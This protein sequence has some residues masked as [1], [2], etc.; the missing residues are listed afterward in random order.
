MFININKII[1]LNMLFMSTMLV[2]SSN[3]WLSSWMGLEINLLAFIPLMFQKNNTLNSEFCMKY[4]IIQA[5][6]SSNLFLMIMINFSNQWSHSAASVITVSLN[7]TLLLKLGSSPFHL[8]FIQIIEG[9]SWMNVFLF[10]TWQKIAPFILI[11]FMMNNKLF[12]LMAIINSLTGA[13]QGFNQTY[14]RKIISFSSIYNMGWM[15]STILISENLWIFYFLIYMILTGTLIWTFNLINSNFISQIFL[16]NTNK[17]IMLM[18]LLNLLSMGGLP[19]LLGF[20]PKWV[21]LNSLITVSSWM[22]LILIMTSLINLFYYIRLMYPHLMLNKFEIKW[23]NPPKNT[24]NKKSNL[25][26]MSLISLLGIPLISL[27]NWM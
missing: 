3:S 4:F 5:L 26:Y 16:H 15:M 7:L 11:M 8:W 18:L 21:A 20:V 9:I 2:I 24:F 1:F 17:F 25:F 19:P 6:S 10:L 22:P 13:I 23:F 14:L 12:S 27:T